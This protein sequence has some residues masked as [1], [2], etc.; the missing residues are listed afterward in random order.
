MPQAGPAGT[1]ALVSADPLRAARSVLR[2]ALGAALADAKE[3]VESSPPDTLLAVHDWVRSLIGRHFDRAA[4]IAAMPSARDCLTSR[5]WGA[6]VE[7]AAGVAELGRDPTDQFDEVRTAL[8]HFANEVEK[9]LE[10]AH[11][12]PPPQA[13]APKPKAPPKPKRE[14]GDCRIACA[15]ARR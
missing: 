9:R 11:P 5:R 14:W 10:G 13:A 1:G 8:C 12:P 3:D 15:P 4:L 7:R 6:L 2:G